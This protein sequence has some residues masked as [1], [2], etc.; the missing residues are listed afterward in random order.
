M[1]L[2]QVMNI[3]HIY[4][5]QFL[6]FWF[7]FSSEK[8]NKL[9]EL[10]KLSPHNSFLAHVQHGFNLIV[11][12][13]TTFGGVRKGEGSQPELVTVTPLIRGTRNHS[14]PTVSSGGEFGG[15]KPIIIENIITLDGQVI[16]KRIKKVTD[17]ILLTE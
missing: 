5:Q 11:N 13:L 12:I 2:D 8:E 4:L 17:S 9:I 14:G 1:V 16:D 3:F 7:I 10:E 6:L 15:S